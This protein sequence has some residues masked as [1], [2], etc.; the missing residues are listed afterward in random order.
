MAKRRKL[1]APS[2][3]DL[4]RIEA[5]FR[6]ETT[7]RGPLAGGRPAP[8]AQVAAEAAAQAPVADPSRRAEQAR[9][10]AEAGRLRQA[11]ADGL[12]MVELPL[13]DIDADAMIRDRAVLD[14]A[15]MAELEAS[16]AASGLRLPIEVF[17][18][19]EPRADGVRYGLISGYRRLRAMRGLHGQ[20]GA[21]EYAA[22]KAL[23]RPR[24]GSDDAFAAMVEENEVRAQ[25]SHFERGRIVV[26]AMQQGAFASVEDAVNRM[27][28]SASKAKRSKVRSFALVFEE[29]GDMLTYPEGLTEKQGLRLA[30]ALR[31]GFAARLRESLAQAAPATAE[32]EW[33]I[34]DPLL[35]AADQSPRDLSKGGRP[36]IEPGLVQDAEIWHAPNGLRL[37]VQRGETGLVLRVSGA[38]LDDQVA[39]ALTDAM[40]AALDQV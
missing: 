40:K 23:V 36:R 5:E 26:I 31:Q 21:A 29:L 4:S 32:E 7:P 9:L 12:L 3:D 38:G 14:E 13:S 27:F 8:I 25:L 10:E 6:R 15:E 2:V 37:K 17:E 24:R 18:L 33:A 28:A 34:L 20:T 11:Q 16:I 39:S 22:I 1:E 19:A 30:Q 35:D